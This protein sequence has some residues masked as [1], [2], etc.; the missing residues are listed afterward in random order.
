[1]VLCVSDIH[2]RTYFVFGNIYILTW[3]SGCFLAC[4]IGG[5]IVYIFLVFLTGG[6]IVIIWTRGK[7]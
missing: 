6:Y 2:A 3:R 1:M 7:M 5:K 4:I